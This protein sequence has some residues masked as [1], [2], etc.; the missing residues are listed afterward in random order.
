MDRRHLDAGTPVENLHIEMRKTAGTRSRIVQLPGMFF[1][2][3][4]DFRYRLRRKVLRRGQQKVGYIGKPRD[5]Y[6]VLH[7]I[8][9]HL[10]REQH[11]R[12]RIGR[13]VAYLQRVAIRPRARHFLDREN[14]ER[15]RLVID[16]TGL[17]EDLAQLL[18]HDSRDDVGCGARTVRQDEPDRARRKFILRLGHARPAS[19]A[20]DPEQHQGQF[21]HDL[22]LCH[23][24]ELALP[25]PLH[26]ERQSVRS[27]FNLIHGLVK[28][29][30]TSRSLP[31]IEAG[32]S[33]APA[34]KTVH[35]GALRGGRRRRVS[36]CPGL[37]CGRRRGVV[38]LRGLAIRPAMLRLGRGIVRVPGP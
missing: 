1:G 26:D 20:E 27:D 25:A 3:G 6:H 13:H 7:V 36:G 12:D 24:A 5:R 30:K 34:T 16:D 28:A 21:F 18:A 29:G 14:A 15:A 37:G 8:D 32:G 17:A 11:G 33:A 19:N 2:I 35:D 22:P 31:R 23:E 9:L 10:V 38:G 4:H